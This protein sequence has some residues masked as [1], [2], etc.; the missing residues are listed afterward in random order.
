MGQRALTSLEFTLFFCC[1]F[2]IFDL[3]LMRSPFRI[4]LLYTPMAREAF[5]YGKGSVNPCNGVILG[6]RDSSVSGRLR[7][8][9]VSSV[10]MPATAESISARR[11]ITD[12]LLR[13]F[14]SPLGVSLRLID[15]LPARYGTW[16]A[17]VYPLPI[18][19]PFWGHVQYRLKR[20]YHV[21][22]RALGASSSGQ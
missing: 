16:S 17:S 10:S 21:V 5:T 13:A 3:F 6:S 9:E 20:P 1:Q 14:V 4:A 18:H 19:P 7:R 22:F 15:A 11:V 8:P 2:L 12:L